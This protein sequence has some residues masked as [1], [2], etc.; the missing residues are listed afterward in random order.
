MGAAGSRAQ[1][2]EEPP[3]R[4]WACYA[5]PRLARPRIVARAR[6]RPRHNYALSAGAPSEGFQA[7]GT[8]AGSL[9]RRTF[10]GV[11]YVRPG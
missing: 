11:E 7:A 10:G 8:P 3:L 2:R 9:N 5:G 4:A 1:G 6:S